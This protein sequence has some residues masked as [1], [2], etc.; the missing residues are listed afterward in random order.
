MSK[1]RKRSRARRP[2]LT[3]HAPAVRRGYAFALLTLSALG[4]ALSVYLVLVHHR[5]RAEPGWQSACAISSALDCDVV[6]LSSYS[7]VAGTP[8]AALGAW[9]YV[10][11]GAVAAVGVRR[12]LHRFPRSPAM[13]LFLAGA[14][15]TAL[16]V[17]LAMT[18]AIAIRALCVVCSALY[19][20]NLGV[21]LVSWRAL[22]Q[23]GERL[24]QAWRAE[25]RHWSRNPWHAFF[26]SVGIIASFLVLFFV[27]FETDSAASSRICTA[28]AEAARHQR[29]E[30]LGIVMYTDFQCPP[31]K[32]LDASLRPFRDHLRITHRHYPL[33]T[34]C[35]PGPKR[36]RHP[37]ACLQARA[38][39]CAGQVGR[40]DEY[41]D[42]LFDG[43][44]SDSPG[45]VELAASLGIDR[46][47]FSACVQAEETAR[48]L[49]ASIDAAIGDDVRATPTMFVGGRRHVGRL[50]DADLA[51]LASSARVSTVQ[52]TRGRAATE[53]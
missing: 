2:E 48:E 4:L 26:T 3:L 52:E 43:G 36:T 38:A 25:R 41:S 15:A 19:V 23:T 24:P 45:L 49:Q 9:F 22:R 8:L 35:N 33:D 21:L 51:C 18:S 47:G 50:N 28:V 40:Y 6:I 42:R 11:T 27:Y 13:C 12:S 31:C 34:T 29:T 1:Q 7:M 46:T 10:L 53:R 44:P 16:S 37:G 14:L 32:S 39:I 20:V 17:A 5:V 30:P